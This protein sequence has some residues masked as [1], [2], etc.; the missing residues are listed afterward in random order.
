MTQRIC[1]TCKGSGRCPSCEGRGSFEGPDHM[2]A[3]SPTPAL[4]CGTCFGG[5]RCRECSGSGSLGEAAL[6][7]GD[8]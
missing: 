1:P 4:P 2:R 3:S 5:G 8:Q 7:G 6:N